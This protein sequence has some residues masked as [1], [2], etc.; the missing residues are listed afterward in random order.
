MIYHLRQK[1]DVGPF[2]PC[3][4]SMFLVG[5]AFYIQKISKIYLQN[6]LKIMQIYDIL[7]MKNVSERSFNDAS[8]WRNCL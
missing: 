1:C 7:Y 5:R 8:Y 2:M 3:L 4:P 6:E